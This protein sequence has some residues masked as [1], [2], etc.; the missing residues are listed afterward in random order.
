MVIISLLLSPLLALVQ[1][2]LKQMFMVFINNTITPVGNIEILYSQQVQKIRSRP[3]S[4]MKNAH[5]TSQQ[6]KIDQA[7][8]L[9]R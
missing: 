5:S 3:N 9:Y 8:F 7:N 2:I 6:P 4:R 1:I